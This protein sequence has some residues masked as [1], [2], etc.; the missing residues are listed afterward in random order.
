MTYTYLKYTKCIYMWASLYWGTKWMIPLIHVILFLWI[1]INFLFILNDLGT[2]DDITKCK[3]C[4]RNL[5]QTN[6]THFSQFSIHTVIHHN[7]PSA[8]SGV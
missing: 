7:F 8:R 1:Y 5:K 3:I 4:G 6:D 2:L